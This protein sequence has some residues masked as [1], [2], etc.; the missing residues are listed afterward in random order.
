MSRLLSG[1]VL[2]RALPA[3]GLPVALHQAIG[4]WV[5]LIGVRQLS[6]EL[7]LHL[8]LPQL[9]KKHLE[10]LPTMDCLLAILLMGLLLLQLLL[11]QV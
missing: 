1:V 7:L 4:V 10:H 9:S 5:E 11:P 2:E 3:L 8:I 6:G